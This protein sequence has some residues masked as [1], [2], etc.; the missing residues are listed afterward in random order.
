MSNLTKIWLV[1]LL[2]LFGLG[3]G[4]V[5]AEAKTVSLDEDTIAKGYTIEAGME[6]GI[7][8]NVFHEPS[9][10]KLEEYTTE[11][12]GVENAE[13]ISDIWLYDIKM[14]TPQV[15]S[16]P[17]TL[18][19]PFSSPAFTNKQIYVWHRD[20]EKWLPI[21]TDINETEQYARAFVHFPF[22]IVAVFEGEGKNV[23]RQSDS[24]FPGLSSAAA[25]AIDA[26]TGT[27]LYQK[28]AN[29]QRS[30]AS[31]TKLMTAQVFL[32]NNPGWEK[33]V[34]IMASDNVGGASI[35][36]RA[37]EIIT[38]K[39]LFWTMLVGSKNNAVKALVRSTGFSEVDF[40]AQMNKQAAAWGLTQTGFTEPTGLSAD[41]VSSARDYARLS[42]RVLQRPEV[43]Q[44]S[45]S[46][47]YTVQT[48]NTNRVI[49]VRNTNRLT[50]GSRYYI[51]GG[52]TGF[53]YEAGYCL[54]TRFRPNTSSSAEIIT[55]LLGDTVY[56]RLFSNTEAV[57]N[58]VY[59]TFSW[60]N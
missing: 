43:M 7:L 3:F 29:D 19:I 4:L 56:G 42:Q 26:K 24:E 40:V 50:E 44:A 17:I 8:P 49:G 10:V 22:S 57:G 60:Q 36:L 2:I 55:V 35:D 41:N 21:P 37:G 54:M 16:K 13:L 34:M 18:K 27:V 53:T 32:D 39:D 47:N 45:A 31:L 23:I 51:S 20:Q 1:V 6:I 15:L 12:P 46:A 11:L 25:V 33:Q 28:N 5:Q 59:N 52:K 48:L 38:V 9:R 14:Q 58:W 30:I